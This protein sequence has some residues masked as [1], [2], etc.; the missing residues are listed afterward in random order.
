MAA[1]LVT[2][3]FTDHP[4]FFFL[5][6]DHL[7]VT[8]TAQKKISFKTF[9]LTDN[10]PDHLRALMEMDN[11]TNAVFLPSNTTSCSPWIKKSFQLTSLI[12]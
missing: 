11:K 8:H 7:K 1:H 12:I 4:F 5:I 9:P 6:T 3:S 2:T 10:E